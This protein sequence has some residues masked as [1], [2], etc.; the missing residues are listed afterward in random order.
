MASD[1]PARSDWL[2]SESDRLLLQALILP[3]AAGQAAYRAWSGRV[4]LD[5]VAGPNFHLLPQLYQSLSQAGADSPD[6]ARLKG[7]HRK[8]WY[9]N[10]LRLAELSAMLAALAAAG[11]EPLLLRGAIPRPAPTARSNN[12]LACAVAPADAPAALEA[13]AAAGWRRA[14]PGINAG[15]HWRYRTSLSFQPAAGDGS[16]ELVW[17]FAP[18]GG[19]AWTGMWQR[20]RPAR[21]G[22]CAA[23]VPSD[24]DQLWMAVATGVAWTPEPDWRWLVDA[25]GLIQTG[26]INWTEL[27]DICR[28]QH[29]LRQMQAAL[30]YQ[31]NELQVPVPAAVLDQYRA[32]TISADEERAFQLNSRRRGRVGA[33]LRHWQKYASMAEG[34]PS[35]A[36]FVRYLQAT[37]ALPSVNA[38]LRAAGRRLLRGS[39]R[40]R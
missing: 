25:A 13:L 7:I 24:T 16:I 38:T 11:V 33:G 18:T 23:R 34:H 2:P 37:W 12:D 21:V 19:D 22:D 4:P 15:R 29:T 6:L 17:R 8:A 32:A 3:G 9:E 10:Q 27:M 39:S 20:S 36:G 1:A 14:L 40:A 26:S 31:A 5:E 35:P 28:Q 30:S